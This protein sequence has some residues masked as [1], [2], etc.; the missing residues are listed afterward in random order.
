M[1]CKGDWQYNF[2]PIWSNLKSEVAC[3]FVCLFLH[4]YS[5]Q[6]FICVYLP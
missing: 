4:E 3:L 5:S 1:C 6:S 2:F